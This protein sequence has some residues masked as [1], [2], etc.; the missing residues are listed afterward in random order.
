MSIVCYSSEIS[1]ISIILLIKSEIKL[2]KSA[3]IVLLAL[4]KNGGWREWL[5]FPYWPWAHFMSI[6]SKPC[7]ISIHDNKSVHYKHRPG[8]A[9]SEL[10]YN[11]FS[12]VWRMPGSLYIC[13]D[14]ASIINVKRNNIFS[15]DWS[16]LYNYTKG[17]LKCLS[18]KF[19]NATTRRSFSWLI[20]KEMLNCLSL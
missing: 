11:V 13:H 8:L 5:I 6:V 1:N 15:E 3:A 10:S 16:H 2:L 12:S 4:K 17:N 19:V 9:D 7:I 18:K 14:M 20:P